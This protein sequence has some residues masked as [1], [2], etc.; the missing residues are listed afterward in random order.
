MAEDAAHAQNVQNVVDSM[1]AINQASVTTKVGFSMTPAGEAW[2]KFAQDPLGQSSGFRPQLSVS[3]IPDGH[4]GGSLLLVSTTHTS[5][6]AA[7]TDTS[8]IFHLIGHQGLSGGNSYHLL[9]YYHTTAAND[10]EVGTNSPDA[11]SY[12]SPVQNTLLSALL[13]AGAKVR[14]VGAAIRVVAASPPEKRSGVL[15]PFLSDVVGVWNDGTNHYL[16]Y[17]SIVQRRAGNRY[18]PEEGVTVRTQF[19]YNDSPFAT[20]GA[21]YVPATSAAGNL[22]GTMPGVMIIGATAT[23]S[24]YTIT[25][26][27]GYEMMLDD[28][29]SPFAVTDSF[30]D[31]SWLQ[32]RDFV[33][34]LPWHTTGHSFRSFLTGLANVGKKVV[35]SGVSAAQNIWKN[36]GVIASSLSKMNPMAGAVLASSVSSEDKAEKYARAASGPSEK[37]KKGK[38]TTSGA[39]SKS[40]ALRKLLG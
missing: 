2:M 12:Y 27:V 5:Y 38:K 32:M 37:K 3:R 8:C 4:G 10:V 14:V 1:R 20:V 23:D 34:H 24:K 33:D 13:T 29:A 7:A 35:G 17:G 11:F 16:T 9:K 26:T 30:A 31:P 21:N 39:A 40:K 25:S 19:P 15:V 6:V 36:R 22:L 28:T 18:T